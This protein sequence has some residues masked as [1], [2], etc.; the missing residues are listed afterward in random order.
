MPSLQIASE[1]SDHALFEGLSQEERKD[2]ARNLRLNAS[3][4]QVL[5]DLDRESIA[6]LS[7]KL[8]RDLPVLQV[9][10]FSHDIHSLRGLDHVRRALFGET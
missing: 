7:D 2:F 8:P 10:Y 9:P 5:A 6:R 4:F 1:L 3:Q